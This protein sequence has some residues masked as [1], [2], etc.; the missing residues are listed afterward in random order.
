VFS[1]V[2]VNI[3]QAF[4]SWNEQ[5]LQ[6]KVWMRLGNTCFVYQEKYAF[7]RLVPLKSKLIRQVTAIHFV[8]HKVCVYLICKLPTRFFQSERTKLPKNVWCRLGNACFVY[9]EN[10]A[11]YRLEALKTKLTRQEKAIHFVKNCVF[12]RK[13]K[14]PTSFSHLERTEIAKEC[15]NETGKHMFCLS[16]KVCFLPCRTT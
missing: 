5:N 1:C 10:Y 15:V 13:R 9:I 16:R 2:N 14:H 11:F 8:K 12:M 7:Y 3:L 4:P 6:K